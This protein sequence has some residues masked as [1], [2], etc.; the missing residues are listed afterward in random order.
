MGSSGAR[1]GAVLLGHYAPQGPRDGA[2]RGKRRPDAATISPRTKKKKKN[3]GLRLQSEKLLRK[4]KRHSWAWGSLGDAEAA[5]SWKELGPP[6]LPRPRA[7]GD[8]G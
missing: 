5:S 7:P 4:G 2:R 3:P 6:A 1:V 8:A